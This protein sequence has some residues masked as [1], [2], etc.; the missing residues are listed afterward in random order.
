[1]I[2]Q[3]LSNKNKNA[4]V[5]KN[6]NFYE[7]NKALQNG[8]KHYANFL[9]K[10]WLFFILVF[11]LKRQK[12]TQKKAPR[13]S[14]EDNKFCIFYETKHDSENFGILHFITPK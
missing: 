5:T 6:Q 9:A 3:Y 7:L 14:H 1:V 2:G 8:S 10:R 13:G 12:K 11:S 4:T